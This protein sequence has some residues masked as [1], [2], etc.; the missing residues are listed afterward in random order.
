MPIF[1]GNLPYTNL[2][3]LNN[4][5]VVKTVKE[6]KDKTDEIDTAVSEAKEY[7]E[8]AK[9]SEENAKESEDNAKVSELNAKTYNDNMDALKT[10]IDTEV[11]ALSTRIDANSLGISTNSARI[12][13]FTNLAQGST[14]GDAELMD[15]RV[16]YDGQTKA[17]AGDA[18]RDQVEFLTD[19]TLLGFNLINNAPVMISP[20]LTTGKYVNLSGTLVTNNNPQLAVTD[21]LPVEPYI[22]KLVVNVV[23]GFPAVMTSIN[24]YD[25]TYTWLSG[26]NDLVIEGNNLPVNTKYIRINDFDGREQHTGVTVTYYGFSKISNLSVDPSVINKDIFT[27]KTAI[28]N[29]NIDYTNGVQATNANFLASNFIAVEPETT[30]HVMRNDYKVN[31]IGNIAFYNS[32]KQ[33]ISGQGSNWTDWTTPVGAAYTRFSVYMY[34]YTQRTF[35]FDGVY[36]VKGSVGSAI[37]DIAIMPTNQ[38]SPLYNKKWV[39]I[40]DSLTEVN[41]RADLRYWNYITQPYNMTFYNHGVGGSGYINRQNVNLAFYQIANNIEQ[42]ADIITVF[43]GVNDCLLSTKPIGDITDNTADTWCG[44]VNLCIT[45]IRSRYL[46]APLGIISPLPCAWTDPNNESAY[47]NQLPSD[48]TCRMSL[49]VEKLSQICTLRGVPFLDLFHTSNMLPENSAFNEEYYSCW[50]APTGDGLHPNS[51][52]HKLFYSKIEKFLETLI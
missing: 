5:W 23:A 27:D 35:S 20:A 30:Y 21:F 46:Y 3:E 29:A 51:K 26:T 8:N 10:Q 42:D 41:A 15:I 7:S 18:V 45:N 44:C 17:T 19:K 47:D 36:I 28:Q 22:D 9:T 50:S 43:G 31:S 14:T 6:V 52:G 2:H 48:P 4:D 1:D 25:N 37:N 11:D 24:F 12:D 39:A 33:Y 49:F 40:G 38:Y 16:T 32:R 13:S 34:P